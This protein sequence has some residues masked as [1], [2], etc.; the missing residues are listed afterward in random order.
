ME[1]RRD[2][3][4]VELRINEVF[5]SLQGEGAR[6]GMPTFFI[7]LSGC[8]QSCS[9]CDTDHAEHRVLALGMLHVLLAMEHAP[10]RSIVWTGGEPALQLT[11]EM[12]GWFRA[13]GFFQAIET[14]GGHYV[15]RGLDYVAVSPKVPE[16]VLRRTMDNRGVDELR[17][18]IKKGDPLPRPTVKAKHLFLSPVFNGKRLVKE[19]V[20]HCIELIKENPRWR[21][22]I[23]LH[24]LLHIA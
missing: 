12:V 18:P 1:R 23:Q 22:S 14:N 4:K 9:Y 8:D 20:S 11:D 7:R 13:L 3:A 5:Y 19:N 2:T 6:V 21:L 16:G 24:K 15:P 17:Y 10:C